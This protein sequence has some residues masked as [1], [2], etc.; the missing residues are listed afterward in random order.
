MAI[1]VVKMGEKP[2]EERPPAGLAMRGTCKRCETEV[3]CLGEDVL[4]VNHA[5]KEVSVVV[6]SCPGCRNPIRVQSD[7]PWVHPRGLPVNAE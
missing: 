3:E 6:G 4:V 1:T 7:P 2:G 5:G